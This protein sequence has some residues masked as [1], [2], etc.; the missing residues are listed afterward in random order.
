MKRRCKNCRRWFV[1]LYRHRTTYCSKRCQDA[2]GRTIQNEW[3]HKHRELCLKR[4][5][6][7]PNRYITDRKAVLKRE[8]GITLVQYQELFKT[9]RGRCRICNKKRPL[10]VGHC[11]RT[12]KV[13][14]LLC[15]RCNGGIGMLNDSPGLLRR[16]IRYLYGL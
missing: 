8:Y 10:V 4:Q 11:H 9:Q 13:R 12:K 15:R 1:F 16:A 14:G 3:Y 6:E 5:R 7:N 2:G